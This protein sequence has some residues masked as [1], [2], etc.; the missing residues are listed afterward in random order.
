MCVFYEELLPIKRKE[1]VPMLKISARI[2][3][4]M[5]DSNVVEC[6]SCKISLFGKVQGGRS[7]SLELSQLDMYWKFYV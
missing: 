7:N 1:Y 4:L 5:V 3:M 6:V 2:W